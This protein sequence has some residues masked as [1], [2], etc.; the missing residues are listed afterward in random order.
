[1][2]VSP[3]HTESL[4]SCPAAALSPTWAKSLKFTEHTFSPMFQPRGL[5]VLIKHFCAQGSLNFSVS[6]WNFDIILDT[7]Q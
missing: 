7:P 2:I 1:M 5:F 3:A 6:Q 4:Q